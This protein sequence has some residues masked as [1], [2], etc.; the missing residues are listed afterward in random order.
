MKQNT[1]LGQHFMIDKDLLQ[2]IV[3]VANIQPKDTILEIGPGEGALT[4]LL[5]EKSEYITTIEIDERFEADLHGNALELIEAVEFN[6]LISN[7]PYHISEPLFVKCTFLQPKKIIVVVGA[8]FAKKLQEETII[9]KVFRSAYD[10]SL[11][12][13][14]SAESFDPPP[15]VESALISCTLKSKHSSLLDFYAYPKSKVKNYLKTKTTKKAAQEFINKLSLP[16]QE[17]RLY[18]L[19]TE[20]FLTLAK[21]IEEMV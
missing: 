15:A 5:R 4:R 6:A 13:L 12:Q 21:I 18:E 2:K 14:I 9:G 11:I 1:D 19:N 10:V 17:K 8:A 7:L 20:E 3:E 16:L